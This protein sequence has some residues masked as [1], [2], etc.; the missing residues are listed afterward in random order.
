MSAEK[1]YQAH[2][3]AVLE[4]GDNRIKTIAAADGELRV[5]NYIALFGGRDLQHLMT[6][7]NADGSLGEFFTAETDFE[8]DY[9]QTGVLHVDWEHGDGKA[10]D[11]LG[12][13]RD[14]VLGYADWKTAV[15]DEVGLWVE[16]VLNRRNRYVQALETLI[17]EGLV[18][19]SSEAVEGKTQVLDNGEIVRWPLRRDTLTVSPAEPRMLSS[20]AV[21]A[22]KALNV[23]LPG[24]DDADP[25]GAQP[26]PEQASKQPDTKPKTEKDSRSKTMSKAEI[27]AEFA[28]TMGMDVDALTDAQRALA[29]RGTEWEQQ[30]DPEP[31]TAEQAAEIAAKAAAAAIEQFKKTAPPI[32]AKPNRGA[33]E[34]VT[35]EADQPF[36]NE[37]EF[38]MAV[39]HAALAPH[40][41]D[42]RL[43]SRKAGLGLNESEPDAGGFLVGAQR[44]D[45]IAQ[46][47]YQTGE[48]LKRVSKDPVSGPNNS[49]TYN[50]VDETSRAD[51]SRMGGVQGYWVAEG[52]TL[53]ASRPQFD[54]LE[55]KLKKVAAL[56]Y[57]TDEQ[58]MDAPQLENWLNREVPNELVFK[59]EDAI[60][61]GDG[62]GKPLGLMNSGALISV[63]R[64]DA[65]EVD[66]PD[67][68]NMWARRWAGVG[69]QY[70]WLAEQS[71]VPQLQRM[72]LGD[73]PVYLPPG[74]LSASPYGMLF[75]RP[76]IEIEYAAALGTAG[77]LMLVDLSQYQAIDRGGIQAASSMHV[78]FLTDEMA[79]RFIYRFDGA[80]FWKSALTPKSGGATRSPYV[81]LTA[82]S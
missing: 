36:E 21:A 50:R 42:K 48:L 27:L 49:M 66:V 60:Y 29:L 26:A 38:F 30:A 72:T 33:V 74:G 75:G 78:Q 11:G 80:P 14:E 58:L 53:T 54:Q 17:N 8:S 3:T 59:V 28:K 32:N 6:G 71:V 46:R 70:A 5:G 81:A 56:A 77:D 34:V 44:A 37:G 41:M 40:Q 35:D 16:R 63:T 68:T 22:C 82:S 47:M 69:T 24:F 67:V 23:P 19:N 52:A 55:L 1:V 51:G 43:K 76:V 57:A 20:N 65:N 31:V 4:R 25:D 15:R 13:G 73:Q 2:K 61:N 7:P 12:P 39:K 64:T 10:I 45:G 79:Y 9:T 62:V 18:G